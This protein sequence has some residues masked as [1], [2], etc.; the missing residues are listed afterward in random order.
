M[1]LEVVVC[2][3]ELADTIVKKSREKVEWGPN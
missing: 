1:E 2:V 3:N